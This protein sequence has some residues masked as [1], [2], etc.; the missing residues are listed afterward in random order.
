VRRPGLRRVHRGEGSRRGRRGRRRRGS[1]GLGLRRFWQGQE[2]AEAD[3]GLA[4]RGRALCPGHAQ[5]RR[6]RPPVQLVHQEG[7]PCSGWYGRR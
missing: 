3:Q 7:R 4:V 5:E 1:R 2:V 6:A